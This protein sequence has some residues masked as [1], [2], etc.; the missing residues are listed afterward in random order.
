MLM[1][2]NAA[3]DRLLWKL[4][5]KKATDAEALRLT[6]KSKGWQLRLDRARSTDTAF[7]REGRR[8]LLMD[9]AIADATADMT[10]DARTTEAGPRLKMRTNRE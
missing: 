1:V 4:S 5:H 2:T 8:V 9:R 3:L 10:M 6:R 7:T